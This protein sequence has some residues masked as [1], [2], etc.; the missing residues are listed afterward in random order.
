V[1]NTKKEGEDGYE[2]PQYFNWKKPLSYNLPGTEKTGGWKKKYKEGGR[3]GGGLRG[4]E[5]SP[6]KAA[7]W[8]Y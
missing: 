2:L 1:H 8:R 3:G 7:P 5:Y 6:A 4:G